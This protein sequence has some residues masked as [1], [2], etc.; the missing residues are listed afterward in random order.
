MRAMDVPPFPRQINIADLE[1]F[2]RTRL[3]ETAVL[4]SDQAIKL[5]GYMC[6]PNDDAARE[7]L[8]GVLRRWPDHSG[9]EMPPIPDR[10]GRIQGDWLKVADIFHL[11]CDL[12]E[13]RHQERR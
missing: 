8:M 4:W 1:Y 11:Y 9:S 5:L 12:I 2:L 13:G 7:T 6:H 10:L 3:S